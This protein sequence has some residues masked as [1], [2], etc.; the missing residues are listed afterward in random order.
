MSTCKKRT[1][2]KSEREVTRELFAG[3]GERAAGRW[4]FLILR[5]WSRRLAVLR[6]TLQEVEHRTRRGVEQRS[7]SL[8]VTTLAAPLFRNSYWRSV[9]VR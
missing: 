4:Y 1:T 6:R 5:A 3:E 9:S 2:E 7:L 8:A